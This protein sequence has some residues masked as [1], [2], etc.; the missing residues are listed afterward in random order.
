MKLR[1]LSTKE[2]GHRQFEVRFVA[3]KKFLLQFFF[4]ILQQWADV[5]MIAFYDGAGTGIRVPDN[6][7]IVTPANKYQDGIKQSVGKKFFC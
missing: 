1:I 3:G 5:V 6:I 2:P 7:G 4:Y